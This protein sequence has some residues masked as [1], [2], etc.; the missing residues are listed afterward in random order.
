LEESIVIIYDK[1]ITLI[2]KSM[3]CALPSYT[4][5][6]YEDGLSPLNQYSNVIVFKEMY[7]SLYFLINMGLGLRSSIH[8]YKC[9]FYDNVG[10]LTMNKF[11]NFVGADC[12][13]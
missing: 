4:I 13:K 12:S 8:T 7:M 11:K 10:N 1:R 3:F 2:T 6:D 5:Y 9:Y